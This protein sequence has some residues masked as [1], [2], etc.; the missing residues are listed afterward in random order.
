[1]SLS[2]PGSPDAR[3]QDVG[4]V[5]VDRSQGTLV[6]DY[7]IQDNRST[8]AGRDALV[9][10]GDI[11]VQALHFHVGGAGG[12]G[13]GGL[14]PGGTAGLVLPAVSRSAY[15]EQV[16]QVAPP[17]LL[18]RGAELAELGR[19]C[20]DRDGPPYAWWR[21]GPWAGKS[22]LLSSFVLRPPAGVAARV[23]IVSFFVTARLA[24]QDTR[25]A[26]IRVVLEQLAAL[27]G[28]SLP[29][30]LPESTRDAYL[31]DLMSRAAAGCEEAG[32]RL[33]LV[34]DGLDEDRGLA[35]GPYVHSIAGLLPGNPPSGMRVI[36]AGRPDPP[37]PGDVPDWHPLRDPAIVRRLDASPYARDVQRLS[38]QEL[39][40]L[41]T[42][43]LERDVL[44][45][46]TAAR[47][48]LTVQDLAGLAGAP[49]WDVERIVHTVAGRTLQGRPSLLSLQ[50]R[51]T[52][53]L[54]GHEELQAA[55]VAYLGDRIDDFRRRL[56]SWADG[57]RARGWP[58]ETPEYLLA[59]Y[60]RLLDDH[61]NLPRMTGLALDAA[62]HARML[63]LAGGDAA[64][65]SEVRAVLGRIADSPTL[66]WPPRWAWPVIAITSPAATPIFLPGSR[67]FWPRS[68]GPPVLWHSPGPSSTR[69]A[70]RGC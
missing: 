42:G 60:F 58:A 4:S 14:K 63:D 15:L 21:A 44:G 48:G 18:G 68:A 70:R 12:G 39:Q 37:V 27:L 23:R 33:V 57:W 25:E 20:L 28:Q 62:R 53:Y 11:R 59:G 47:G 35:T 1:M 7:G 22:A 13:S 54:L 8:A 67:P 51:P 52:V 9:A 29:E 65:L 2:P 38:R 24:A 16:R 3:K 41:L 32:G 66:T 40:R 49:L 6:G 46:L 45:L 69:T 31:L 17:E 56:H 10:G 26:F 64:A 43:A 36:V 55:S 61:G 19:F 50:G 34:V 5:H 30:V